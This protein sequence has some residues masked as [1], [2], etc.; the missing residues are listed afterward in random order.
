MVSFISGRWWRWKFWNVLQVSLIL[1]CAVRTVLSCQ[2]ECD[3]TLTSSSGTFISPCYPYDYPP[4]LTCKWTLQAPAGFVLQLNFLDFELEEAQGCIYDKVVVDTGGNTVKFCGLTANG[5]TLNSS[6]NVMVVTFYSDFSVQKK[7][8]S[9]SY[10]QVAVSLRNQKVTFPQNPKDV[11]LVS[12]SV[13]IPALSQFTI[14][15]EIAGQT[16]TGSGFIFSYTGKEPYLSFG[17]SGNALELIIGNVTCPVHDMVTLADFIGSMQPFCITWSNTNGAVAV[18]FKG[19]YQVKLC[20][21]SVGMRTEIG[22][23]FELGRGKKQGQNYDGLI[24]NFRLWNSA[25][26]YPELSALTCDTVGNVV[27]WDN[28]FWN[29]PASYAQSDSSLSC[30]CFPQCVHLTTTLSSSGTTVPAT[31]SQTT[32]CASSGVSCPASLTTTTSSTVNT[33]TIPTNARTNDLSISTS[34]TSAPSMSLTADTVQTTSPATTSPTTTSTPTAA[35]TNPLSIH[36]RKGKMYFLMKVLMCLSSHCEATCTMLRCQVKCDHRMKHRLIP[37]SLTCPL[38]AAE[39]GTAVLFW[40]LLRLPPRSSAPPPSQ[41]PVVPA[42]RSSKTSLGFISTP[43]IWPVR[44]KP[45]TI[46]TQAPKYS[47]IHMTKAPPLPMKAITYMSPEPRISEALTNA[48]KTNF[49]T[50]RPTYSHALWPHNQT[51]KGDSFQV[52]SVS[53]R[54]TKSLTPQWDLSESNENSSEELDFPSGFGSES[55]LYD[56]DLDE[57]LFSLFEFD[58]T[59]SLDEGLTTT[60]PDISLLEFASAPTTPDNAS[61]EQVETQNSMML[62]KAPGGSDVQMNQTG[63]SRITGQTTEPPSP[64]RPS[65]SPASSDLMSTVPWDLPVVTG[66][67]CIFTDVRRYYQGCVKVPTMSPTVIAHGQT[68]TLEEQY[69][70]TETTPII[71]VSLKYPSDDILYQTELF[72]DPLTDGNYP[73]RSSDPFR[74]E[75]PRPTPSMEV[76]HEYAIRPSPLSLATLSSAPTD[77]TSEHFLASGAN[78]SGDLTL[79][80]SENL[81]ISTLNPVYFNSVSTP[82]FVAPYFLTESTIAESSVVGQPTLDTLHG[83]EPSQVNRPLE[84]IYRQKDN[85]SSMVDQSGLSYAFN[86]SVSGRSEILT[87][88]WDISPSSPLNS[89]LEM[90]SHRDDGLLMFSS[91]SDNNFDTSPVLLDSLK[92]TEVVSVT[93]EGGYAR[94]QAALSDLSVS[95]PSPSLSLTMLLDFQRRLSV[96]QSLKGTSNYFDDSQEHSEMLQLSKLLADES[97]F[98]FQSQK[99]FDEFNPILETQLFPD[100]PAN[101]Y[102]YMRTYSENYI[103]TSKPQI[104]IH[105]TS[106]Y[107]NDRTAEPSTIVPEHTG[108]NT[109]TISQ[110]KLLSKDGSL[111][112]SSIS[113]MTSTLIVDVPH[114]PNTEH[115]YMPGF[116]QVTSGFHH[117]FTF[118]IRQ[119]WPST[120]EASVHS[121]A[122]D[123]H[124]VDTSFAIEDLQDTKHVQFSTTE[125][126]FWSENESAKPSS[127]SNNVL[128]VRPI[129]TDRE[130]HPSP[131]AAYD[132]SFVSTNGT[133]PLA[134]PPNGVIADFHSVPTDATHGTTTDTS[135]FIPCPCKTFFH[136]SCHCGLSS[137]NKFTFYRI[138]FVSDDLQI[139]DEALEQWLNQTFLDWNQTIYVTNVSILTGTDSSGMTINR[140]TALLVYRNTTGKLLTAADIKNR[141]KSF[142]AGSFT[143][144]NIDVNAVE[145]CQ[146]EETPLHYKWP[147]SRPSVTYFIPCFPYKEQNASRT[148]KINADNYSS[149][150]D[151]PNLLNCKDIEEIEVS[152]ENAADVAVQ[153]A[154]ITNNGLSTTELSKVVS[155]VT[156]LVNV[157]RINVTLASTVVNIISNVMISSEA[158]Q[159]AASEMA[160]RTM[161]KLVQKIEFDGPSLTITSKNLAVGISAINSS[162][163][164]GANFSAFMALNSSDPQIDLESEV[165]NSLASVSLPATLLHNLSEADVEIISRIHFMFFSKTGLFQDQ[166]D[167]GMSLNSYVVASSVGN[168]SISNLEDPVEIEIT[169]LQNQWY[170]NRLCVFWD[171]S[172]QNGTGG[173]NSEGCRV[174]AQSNSNKTICLCNHLTHFGVLMDLSGSAVTMNEGNTKILTF[175]TY[176]GCGL[177]AIFSA[178]TILTYVAFEKLRRD[179]PSKILMNLSTSLLFLNM[180]FLLDSWLASYEIQGLCMA[181]AAFLHFFLLTSFTWMGLES[182][183]MYIALVK[184]FNTYIR[185]YILKFCIVGW[186]LPAVIVALVLASDKNSY[187]KEFYGNG[188]SGQGLSEFCWIRNKAVF[189]V[190]CVAYFCVI[191]LL[192]VAMFI[193]V[194]MQICGRNGKRNNRTLQEEVLR[195]LRSVISLTFL[196]GMTWGFAFFAWG[197]VNLAFMYLFSIFN[198]L[199]GLFIFIFHCA[200]KEN[201]Q[202]QWRRYL[203][204]GKL[205]LADNSDWSK[206]ATNNTKKVSSD[207]IGKSLSSSSYGSTTVNWT[208]KARVTLNPFAKR[209]SSSGKPYS[210]QAN[211]KCS[212][213]DSDA[214]SS[215]ST[216]LPVH[217]V[218]DKVKGY[219]SVRSDNFYKNIILSDSFSHSTKF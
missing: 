70:F 204:C 158:M 153:L 118:P 5:L 55:F 148:C 92:A 137:G 86:I 78:D 116:P 88:I 201:V 199:Q 123:I 159:L 89:N 111:M 26:S 25:M 45:E 149:F 36:S 212:T 103:S 219:C 42:G 95:S 58:S 176:I 56:I 211:Q 200:L 110:S 135:E 128:I 195:N 85:N 192:N 122:L 136:S 13:S 170:Q 130:M 23:S 64:S 160:L 79:S 50:R 71:T 60:S 141:L 121:L 216:I 37:F 81:F 49:T 175:I 107:S 124:P 145:N 27:D 172:I 163:F 22:G 75:A 138:A 120:L 156:K 10:R 196:L 210:I 150:W 76:Q 166:Q 202:K 189:Y 131:P 134:S 41:P 32:S 108:A 100:I 144:E 39:K 133:L 187:G 33:N 38:A 98:S 84:P 34:Y 126:L 17:N 125:Q 214:S 161:D 186:G 203:C 101:S 184:V 59:Y 83:L 183:H 44:K 206:T 168:F 80:Q 48:K 7:G 4:S 218:L 197:P 12:S 6:T 9:I 40:S 113:P 63:L 146:A 115:H 114:Q 46:V 167:N 129:T 180:T 217:Q 21:A 132:Q 62:I 154:D 143:L 1:I 165:E 164:N 155:V 69:K 174:S 193:V 173:W 3:E 15:F 31:T 18:Y 162:S 127:N 8:F 57:N 177:S 106:T 102:V 205:R 140:Y 82:S 73:I 61:F 188:A 213:S 24:Y 190:T 215:S 169:H 207:N 53:N 87:D 112:S 117:A 105:P 68:G 2:T 67:R 28:S 151:Q 185:R 52:V 152:Q 54:K 157:A 179:Y 74:A 97:V 209:H 66:T 171:F 96:S 182:V 90:R 77:G 109:F 65:I 191:F 20:S 178:V 30:I 94:N 104:P 14:C 91:T 51:E 147:E 208:S 35:A 142:P 29:I 43:L 16:Q 139:T 99:D 93:E 181:V 11:V 198:S 19:N 47:A 119:S 194:M 72:T